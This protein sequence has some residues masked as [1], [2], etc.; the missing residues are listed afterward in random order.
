MKV[1]PIADNHIILEL[2]NGLLLDVND[3][4]SIKLGRVHFT[5]SERNTMKVD[6]AL[7]FDFQ[8]ITVELSKEK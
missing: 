3:G 8:K 1:I 6:F 4:S 7:L 5:T 2:G